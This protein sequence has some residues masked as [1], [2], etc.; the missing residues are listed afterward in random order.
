[1][2]LYKKWLALPESTKREAVET[3][4]VL[5]FFAIVFGSLWA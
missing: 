2:N 1:M 4:L 3:L 5:C